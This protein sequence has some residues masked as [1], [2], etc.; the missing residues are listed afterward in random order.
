MP[1]EFLWTRR[2]NSVARFCRT[3]K[4]NFSFFVV[5]CSFCFSFNRFGKSRTVNGRASETENEGK[6]EESVGRGTR[7]IISENHERASLKYLRKN[8]RTLSA[9]WTRARLASVAWPAAIKHKIF[10]QISHVCLIMYITARGAEKRRMLRALRDSA[11]WLRACKAAV[12]FSCCIL[13]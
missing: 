5:A 2:K 1:L 13:F 3:K 10:Q 9:L 8:R 11:Q 4:K 6:I 12:L 7:E